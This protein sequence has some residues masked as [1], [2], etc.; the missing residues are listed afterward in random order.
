MQKPFRFESRNQRPE[1]QFK[2]AARAWM[3]LAYGPYIFQLA[4]AGGPYQRAGSPDDVFSIRGLFVA[5]EWKAP[6]EVAGRK[7]R[8]GPRQ[9]EVIAEIRSAGGRAGAVSCWQELKELLAGIEP[10]QRGME[11]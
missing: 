3:K 7:P 9:A 4:I 6:A 10:A 8:I 11:I 5:I 2:K 1:S